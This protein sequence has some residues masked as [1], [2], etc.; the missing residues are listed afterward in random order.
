MPERCDGEDNHSQRG[1]Y[2]SYGAKQDG[3][4]ILQN[5]K[6]IA[7]PKSDWIRIEEYSRTF[8][9]TDTWVRHNSL[10]ITTQVTEAAKAARFPVRLFA[11]VYELWSFN[12]VIRDYRKRKTK[13]EPEYKDYIRNR[14][15]SG[16]K[17]ACSCNYISQKLLAQVGADRHPL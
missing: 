3:N 1:L 2:R 15:I 10:T 14:Y 4:G 12:E 9:S 16:G 6:Q 7:K 5:H 13:L 17:Q 11:S 8:D